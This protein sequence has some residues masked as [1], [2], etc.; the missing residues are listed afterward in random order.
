MTLYALDNPRYLARGNTHNAR[1]LFF[2]KALSDVQFED[3]AVSL[4]QLAENAEN[5]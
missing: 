3:D 1:D 2:G 5:L 4:G